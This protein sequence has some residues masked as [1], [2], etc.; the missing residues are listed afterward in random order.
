VEDAT[1]RQLEKREKNDVT[2]RWPGCTGQPLPWRLVRAPWWST[3][4]RPDITCSGDMW[5]GVPT[6]LLVR[7]RPGCSS[8]RAR[9]KPLTHK[10]PEG[11]SRKCPVAVGSTLPEVQFLP[12]GFNVFHRDRK[13]CGHR[14]RRS[15]DH[16]ALA[17]VGPTHEC[18]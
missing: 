12:E 10:R 8:T 14:Q 15:L 4:T 6:N 1:K 11:A 18:R 17:R 16:L 13:V 2:L 9:P 5:A 3:R 7:V